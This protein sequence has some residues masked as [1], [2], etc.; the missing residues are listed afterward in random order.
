MV[1]VLTTGGAQKC[2]V[3]VLSYPALF[4]PS[5]PPSLSI[6]FP[7]EI[8]RENEGNRQGEGK[9]EEEQEKRMS[10]KDRG[11]REST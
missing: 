5:R 7:S 8:E 11:E 4:M 2:S 10:E 1:G 3:Y 9:S 6:S